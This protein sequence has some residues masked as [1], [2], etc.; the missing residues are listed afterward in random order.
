MSKSTGNSNREQVICRLEIIGRILIAII[1]GYIFALGAGTFLTQ[2][3]P[4]AKSSAVMTA[5]L[6]SFAFYAT[7]IIW[8]FSVKHLRTL[9]FGL[10]GSVLLLCVALI[11]V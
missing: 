8:V 11:L 6:A 2:V 4:I 9:W 5:G 10:T 3:L 7:A 1:G